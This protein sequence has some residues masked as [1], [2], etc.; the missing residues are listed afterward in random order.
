MRGWSDV[1]GVNRTVLVVAIIVVLVL[2]MGSAVAGTYNRLV[3]LQTAVDAQWGQVM[4]VLQRRNDLIPNL[5]ETVKGFA[6]QERAVIGE[7]TEARAKLA[8]AQTTEQQVAASNQLDSALAR[9]LVIVEN[10]PN[11]KSDANFRQLMDGL[12]GTENRI[13]VERGR[14][15]DN[16]RAYNQ[17]LLTFPNNIVAR[18]F[19]FQ[20]RSYYQATPGSETPP[21]VNFGG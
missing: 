7:V 12:A 2:G 20:P 10:Y 14:Y 5:V 21:Q 1:Q 9:L 8:G 6:T 19:G 4:V 17:A 13:A 15:N 18:I 16:V 11:I 3:T